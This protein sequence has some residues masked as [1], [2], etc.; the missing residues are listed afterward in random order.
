MRFAKNTKNIKFFFREI[1]PFFN[2]SRKCRLLFFYVTHVFASFRKI[3]FREKI[4]KLSRKFSFAGNPNFSQSCPG[5]IVAIQYMHDLTEAQLSYFSRGGELEQTA[6]KSCINF[7][8]W[9]DFKVSQHLE[10]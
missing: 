5:F 8:D 3:H 6:L 9:V 4:A 1:S 10:L 2:F 7:Q